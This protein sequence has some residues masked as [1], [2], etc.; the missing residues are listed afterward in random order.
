MP[1]LCKGGFSLK[2]ALIS[3][4]ELIQHQSQWTKLAWFI[5][6]RAHRK[7]HVHQ[8][9]LFRDVLRGRA[10]RSAA[11]VAEYQCLKRAEDHKLLQWVNCYL[12][13]ILF[14]SRL[15]IYDSRQQTHLM[16]LLL[17][18][19]Q[20]QSYVCALSWERGTDSKSLSWLSCLKKV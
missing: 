2:L 16:L 9:N 6:I 1:G 13:F 8:R 15:F 11:P 7:K 5:K 19:P 3:R 18:S 17:F 12:L 10:W 20:Q 14:L 4:A